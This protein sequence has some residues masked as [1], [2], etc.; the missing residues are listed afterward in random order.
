MVKGVCAKTHKTPLVQ[1]RAHFRASF[2]WLPGSDIPQ[3]G[4]WRQNRLDALSALPNCLKSRTSM[5][6]GKASK[7]LT[8]NTSQMQNQP[9]EWALSGQR[10]KAVLGV[11]EQCPSGLFL[12]EMLPVDYLWKKYL[13]LAT[14]Q[15]WSYQ[16][17]CHA[18]E[19]EG[20]VPRV[21]LINAQAEE[22]RCLDVAICL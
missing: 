10:G 19:G 22:W 12:K 7:E 14:Q 3:V 11:G 8:S 5:W 2:V 16:A 18:H 17:L 9:A 13:L 6:V 20:P 1:F 15:E 4:L 21:A